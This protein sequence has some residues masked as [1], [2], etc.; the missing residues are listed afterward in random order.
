MKKSIILVLACIVVAVAIAQE[1]TA[2]TKKI[3]HKMNTALFSWT[4]TVHDF[5]IIKLNEPVTHRFT[6]TNSGEA[7]LLISSV[8]ASCGCT[9]AEYSKEAIPSGNTGFV[10]ATYNAAKAGV[11][12]KTI[13]IHANTG[14][15]A[16]VL[17]IKGEVAE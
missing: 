12:S 13:T 17:T 16:V 9:V 15:E 3:S 6:F 7:A 10:K 8:K 5:G 1:F 2:S 14:E 4:E 11:F